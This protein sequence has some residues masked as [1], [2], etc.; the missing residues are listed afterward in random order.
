[1]RGGGG[2]GAAWRTE[3]VDEMEKWKLEQQRQR[4]Y[5][6]YDTCEPTASHS[7]P[8]I[9]DMYLYDIARLT[10]SWGFKIEH[11][12]IENVKIGNITWDIVLIDWTITR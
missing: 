7:Q 2:G 11:I 4:I 5:D 3:I 12:K 1:M 10:L 6:T 9:Y 8:N